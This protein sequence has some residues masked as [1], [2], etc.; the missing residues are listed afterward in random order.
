MQ[1]NYQSLEFF[2]G[3]GAG[4]SRDV[5]SLYR[6]KGGGVSRVFGASSSRLNA[7]AVTLALEQLKGK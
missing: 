3:V 1:Q 7:T 4:T 5:A 2:K 6:G